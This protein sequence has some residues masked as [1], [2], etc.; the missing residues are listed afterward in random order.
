[1]PKPTLLS[2]MLLTFLGLIW[3]GSFLAV[4]VALEG[5]TPAWIA[6]IRISLAAVI[7]T[8]ASYAMGHGLPDHRTKEGRRLWLHC[9]GMALFSNAIPFTL[10]SW[11]QTEVTAGF[12]GITMAIVPLLVLPLAHVFVPGE[13]LTK[14]KALGF[15]IGFAGVVVLIGPD[16]ILKA[17]QGDL[18]GLARLACI[19]S[20]L[21]YATGSIITRRAPPA[22]SMTF[23]AAA[24]LLA[25]VTLVPFAWMTEGI[26][27]STGAA[28]WLGVLY[29]ALLP[30]AAA[31]L[32]LVYVIKTAGPS[33]LSM[34]NYQVP[35]WAVLLGFIFLD[36]TLPQAFFGALAL[37][38]TGLA[39]AQARFRGRY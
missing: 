20:T 13:V 1:M 34:V 39:I 9:L 24:L 12:A 16:S 22:H 38:L 31:T 10:L 23:S 15:V 36:E 17:G 33:F 25:T 30:T 19:A 7:I 4:E 3:G 14:R 2:W 32:L 26:P 28:P 37:I 21:C 8:I 29:L 18:V 5:F 35:V 27:T 11:G 6:A